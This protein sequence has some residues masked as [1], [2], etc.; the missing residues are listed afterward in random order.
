MDLIILLRS[1]QIEL[2]PLEVENTEKPIN[3]TKFW[4][5]HLKIK[6]IMKD[7]LNVFWSNLHFRK[8]KLKEVFTIGIQVMGI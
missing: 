6:V 4:E 8:D 5:N 2:L 7:Y 1:Y 3:N